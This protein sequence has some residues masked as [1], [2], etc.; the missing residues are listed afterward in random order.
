MK[1]IVPSLPLTSVC[2]FRKAEMP[3]A[4][5]PSMHFTLLAAPDLVATHSLKTF[6]GTT[7]FFIYSKCQDKSKTKSGVGYDGMPDV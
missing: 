6:T 1:R 2:L 7:G 5:R 3:L 4:L